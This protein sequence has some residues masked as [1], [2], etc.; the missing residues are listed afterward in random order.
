MT[1]PTKHSKTSLETKDNSNGNNKQPQMYA[2]NSMDRFGDDLCALLLSYLSIKDR[3]QCECVSKQ[4]QR[5]V[6][7]NAVD[8]TFKDTFIFKT[9]HR[10]EFKT[11]FFTTIARKCPNI[12]TID[13]RG[14]YKT[15]VIKFPHFL[16][17]FRDNCRH[18]R[19]IYCDL[20]PET[21]QWIHSYGSLIT[22][23]RKLE[24]FSRNLMLGCKR[25]SHIEVMSMLNIG[26]NSDDSED[27]DDSQEMKARLDAKLEL[28]N[29]LSSLARTPEDDLMDN[30]REPIVIDGIEVHFPYKPYGLQLDYMRSMIRCC[31]Q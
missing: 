13:C 16:D 26:S 22:R 31:Q 2:K 20:M 5:T 15:Y 9:Y 30:T 29:T 7:E 19:D 25:L 24:G 1:Q 18:L 21:E 27:S 4:F 17:I 12:Q 8:I 10:N 23:V 3:F 11:R 14:I 28:I 6:F